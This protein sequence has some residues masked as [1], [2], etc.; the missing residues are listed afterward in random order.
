M[1]P[2]QRA[3]W[4]PQGQSQGRSPQELALPEY[5]WSALDRVRAGIDPFTNARID[6]RRQ[7]E[8]MRTYLP[9][10]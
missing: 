10:G 6:A 1:T 4:F 2:E 8:L 5:M 9:I 7:E 3:V